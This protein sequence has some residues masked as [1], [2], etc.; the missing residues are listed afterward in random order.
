MN[1]SWNFFYETEVEN[2]DI[3][4][5]EPKFNWSGHKNVQNRNALCL[6]LTHICSK[7][8]LIFIFIVKSLKACPSE[9]DIG[10]FEMTVKVSP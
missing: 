3:W 1:E 4:T 6:K 10:W 9:G 2:Y 5:S 8:V 7:V